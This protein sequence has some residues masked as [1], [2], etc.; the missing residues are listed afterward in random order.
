[1]SLL[2][3]LAKE[4]AVTKF[5]FSLLTISALTLSAAAQTPAP[6]P[7]NGCGD[8]ALRYEVSADRGFH[9]HLPVAGKAQIFYFQDDDVAGL[10][11][12]TTRI[13]LDGQWIGANR[14]HNYFVFYVDPGQHALCVNW[15][16]PGTFSR[17][18]QPEASLQFD[19]KA[20]QV[21]YFQASSTFHGASR[22]GLTLEPTRVD[23][24]EDTLEDYPLA[25]SHEQH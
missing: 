21:Y 11:R 6:K 16:D 3:R 22:V 19:A 14:G 13:G 7:Q 23:N 25:T 8:P 17:D 10:R 24:L 12:P 9:P 15:Q 20:N 4:S 1:M 18:Q 5:F 2:F